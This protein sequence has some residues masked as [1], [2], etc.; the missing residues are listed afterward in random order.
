[1][2]IADI[3]NLTER[4][5]ATKLID[6]ALAAGATVSVND[7]EQ[8]TLSWSTDRTAIFEAMATTDEDVIR[9]SLPDTTKPIMVYLIY[10][11]GADLISDSSSSPAAQAFLKPIED[12]AEQL[13]K[14]L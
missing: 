9:V 3:R 2:T 13:A 4:K 11:N 1:M 6:T 10:G 14:G 8:T 5:I 12:Y 7:G